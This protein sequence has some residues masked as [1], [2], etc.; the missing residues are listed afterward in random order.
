MLRHL[1]ILWILAIVSCNTIPISPDKIIYS[2]IDNRACHFKSASDLVN[3]KMTCKEIK[4]FNSDWMLV[5][6][7]N[8]REMLL[9]G[10]DAAVA[11]EK[12][13]LQILHSPKDSQ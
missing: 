12:E 6:K 10:F 5:H 9:Q 4:D 7:V 1:R 2:I 3:K 11:S 13:K 8:F